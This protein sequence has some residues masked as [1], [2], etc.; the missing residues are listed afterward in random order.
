[1]ANNTMKPVLVGAVVAGLIIGA[2]FL[3]RSQIVE[4]QGP[5][6]RLGEAIDQTAK[7]LKESTDKLD[8]E[9]G[10]TTE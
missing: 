4:D 10:N 9:I 6:E 2:F 5:A 1:M 8:Q 3:G 7:D